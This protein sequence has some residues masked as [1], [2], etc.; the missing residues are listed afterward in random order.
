MFSNSENKITSES[1]LLPLVLI[2]MPTSRCMSPGISPFR[3]S[4]YFLSRRAF[5]CLV[6]PAA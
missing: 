6:L 4:S 1:L 3:L 2:L 5:S